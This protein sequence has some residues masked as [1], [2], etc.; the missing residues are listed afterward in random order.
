[1]N[2]YLNRT[3][4]RS[5]GPPFL[6]FYSPPGAAY[7][8]FST[9][10]FHQPA[11]EQTVSHGPERLYHHPVALPSDTGTVD[12]VVHLTLKLIARLPYRCLP[13]VVPLHAYIPDGISF[14]FVLSC[15]PSFGTICP[16]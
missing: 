6:V 3:P 9:R 10:L 5:K 11:S 7:V 8:R 14:L 12:Y 15:S 13:T 1:M 16:L 2:P 4:L